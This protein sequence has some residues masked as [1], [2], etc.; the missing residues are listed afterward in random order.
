MNFLE[1]VVFVL[2]SK[3]TEITVFFLLQFLNSFH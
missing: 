1:M 2:D 3:N